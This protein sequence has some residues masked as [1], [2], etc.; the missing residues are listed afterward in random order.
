MHW[1]ADFF[2]LLHPKIN[3]AQKQVIKRLCVE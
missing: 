2:V 1:I 3:Q